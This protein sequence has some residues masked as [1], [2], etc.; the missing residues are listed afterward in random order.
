[1][2][3]SSRSLLPCIAYT[4]YIITSLL[5]VLFDFHFSENSCILALA[6][7][8]YELSTGTVAI[9]ATKWPYF[10]LFDR[11]SN[12][13]GWTWLSV[14]LNFNN[15]FGIKLILFKNWSLSIVFF[16]CPN[17]RSIRIHVNIII[18]ICSDF[19]C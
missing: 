13:I 10:A 17:N 18:V 5:F 11:N 9:R 16:E 2:Y 6:L 15:R 12:T 19:Q 4:W 3:T 8:M 14:F 1:M 7:F